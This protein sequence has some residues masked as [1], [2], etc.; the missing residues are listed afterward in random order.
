MGAILFK[1]K[2][3]DN[4][5]SG[6]YETTDG[7][8]GAVEGT[9]NTETVALKPTQNSADC[10][11]TFSVKGRMLVPNKDI[12]A[13][14][15][16]HDCTGIDYSQGEAR[17]LKFP[18]KPGGTGFTGNYY[19]ADTFD[20]FF[21]SIATQNDTNYRGTAIR[22]DEDLNVTTAKAKG[23]L[24]N[25]DSGCN[26]GDPNYLMRLELADIDPESEI[27][28]VTGNAHVN[29][30]YQ[31]SDGLNEMIVA[32]CFQKGGSIDF[33]SFGLLMREVP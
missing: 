17:I 33:A 32:W 9:M 24:G 23:F 19:G 18:R 16:G 14:F 8:E 29:S 20:A 25:E 10:P 3:S 13:S 12:R 5:V 4:N 2:R 21:L 27:E 1:L 28:Y 26:S 6:T 30:M 15:S 22:I 31:Q 7:G 11:G